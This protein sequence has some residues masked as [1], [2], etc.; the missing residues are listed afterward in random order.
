M[1]SSDQFIEEQFKA[2][3]VDGD[4]LVTID[5]FQFALTAIGET[6]TDEEL[7]A[8]FGDADGDANGRIT[9]AEFTEAW[10]R[11]ESA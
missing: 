3:D 6:V 9:L 2:L 5:E 10:H 8:I 11:S 1:A 4:G 7:R